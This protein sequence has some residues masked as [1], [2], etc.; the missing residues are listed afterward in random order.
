MNIFD[1]NKCKKHSFKGCRQIDKPS[2]C[3][4]LTFFYANDLERQKIASYT[5]Q[6]FLIAR[7]YKKIMSY[8]VQFLCRLRFSDSLQ[9]LK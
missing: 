2:K 1:K 9:A 3:Y 7:F 4:I 6:L 8:N 5:K